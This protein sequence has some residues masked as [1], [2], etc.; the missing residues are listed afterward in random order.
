M[1]VYLSNEHLI[2]III[3]TILI[4]ITFYGSCLKYSSYIEW[5]LEKTK[6]TNK[7]IVP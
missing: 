1:N 5:K 2:H 3:P 6:P 7:I 4:Y